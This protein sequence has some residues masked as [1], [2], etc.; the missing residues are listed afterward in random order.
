MGRR[1]RTAPSVAPVPCRHCAATPGAA[2][3]IPGT[4]QA[5]LTIHPTR[6]ADLDARTDTKDGPR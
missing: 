4:G 3:T 6:Q 2:C 5:L 1:P